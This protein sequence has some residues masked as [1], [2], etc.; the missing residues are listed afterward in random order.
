MTRKYYAQD[1]EDP[2]FTIV[3]YGR[4]PLTEEQR[5]ERRER[6]LDRIEMEEDIYMDPMM[7]YLYEK[8]LEDSRTA[9]RL[10]KTPRFA[11]APFK[12]VLDY[13]KKTGNSDGMPIILRKSN[14]SATEGDG[15]EITPHKAFKNLKASHRAA[16]QEREIER[17]AEEGFFHNKRF[18]QAFIDR[19]KDIRLHRTMTQKQLGALVNVTENDIGAF[20]RGELVYNATLRAKLI[21]KLGL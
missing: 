14:T 20:E 7:T 11:S 4:R 10:A 9:R 5:V 21:W 3:H 17:N 1:P 12:E 6:K 19:I 16:A 8:E 15:N 18:D 2:S 13:V